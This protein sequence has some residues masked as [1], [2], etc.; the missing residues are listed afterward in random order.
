MSSPFKKSRVALRLALALA[1][2]GGAAIVL[3]LRPAEPEPN[4]AQVP[5]SSPP[6]KDEPP[7]ERPGGEKVGVRRSLL[8]GARVEPPAAPPSS[9]EAMG[10]LSVVVASRS[11]GPLRGISV[12]LTAEAL[13]LSR[14]KTT[15][16][17]GRI[18]LEGLQPSAWTVGSLAAPGHEPSSPKTVEIRAGENARLS[19][20]LEPLAS[21][22][23]LVLRYD[24]KPLEGA[25]VTVTRPG[26]RVSGHRTDDK[27]AFRAWMN[28]GTWVRAE[29][30]GHGSAERRVG[31][32]A[33]AQ[34][35]MVLRLLPPPGDV[36]I[37]SRIAGVVVD[38]EG[39]SPARIPV[40]AR[41]DRS[42]PL[43]TVTDE[44]GRFEIPVEPGAPYEVEAR[45]EDGRQALRTEVAPGTTGL[46]LELE[47]GA[48]LEGRVLSDSGSPQSFFTLRWA[49]E[50]VPG[51]PGA[52]SQRAFAHPEG[53]FFIENVRP[54]R[55]LVEAEV[56]RVGRGR[57]SGIDVPEGGRG[58][59]EVRIEPA[60]KI[61]G[62]VLDERT[63]DPLAGAVV[64]LESRPGISSQP[65]TRADERGRFVLDGVPPGRRSV[66]AAVSGYA[67]RI[68]AAL[69]VP[70]G[71]ALGPVSI[72]LEPID[73]DRRLDLVGI[74]A[75]MAAKDGALVIQQV[76]PSGGAAEQGL[77]PGARIR[78]VDGR[79]IE[80]LG[81]DGAIQAIR[82]EE[83]TTV[84]LTIE[85]G[86]GV[87]VITVLRRRVST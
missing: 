15:D 56:D 10:S 86:S 20:I 57:V 53:V 63:G 45:A 80:Q 7:V 50:D 36:R 72:A 23:G 43:S 85:E 9:P 19:L 29:H 76:V 6:T 24:G 58:Y 74:G 30:P 61:E 27:G 38:P 11:S 35:L 17:E 13:G 4:R 77:S 22:R 81:F 1:L 62:F 26:A 67:T 41:R 79:D 32:E 16:A 40:V 68:V 46:R 25:E 3:F 28:E 47:R 37:R 87:R 65:S 48:V 42:A 78:A 83:G 49:E 18:L 59:A 51:L 5:R 55:Y 33:L 8:M 44:D 60:G 73:G 31:A 21:L 12:S 70:S 34:G 75:V 64:R 2:A 82:G 71:A 66:S 39:A 52:P 69:E 54:G 84:Q 14:A